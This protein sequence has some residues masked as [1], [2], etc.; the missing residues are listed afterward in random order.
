MEYPMLAM[1]FGRADASGNYTQALRNGA[2]SVIIHEVGHNFFPMIVNSDERQ[3]WWMD[4]GLNSFCQYVAEQEFEKG[5]P[6]RRGP[7]KNIVN[8]MKMPRE[9]MEPI[10]TKGDAVKDVG[11]NAYAKAATGL[12]MLREVIMG[13][14]LFDFSFREYARRWAFRHPT[15]ADLFRTME[16][17]S[18][19]DLDWFW[20]G[21]YFR[22][23]PVD[24]ALDSV[25]AMQSETPL[26]NKDVY[27]YELNVSNKGGMVMPVIIGWTYKDGTQEKEVV[28][29][30]VWMTNEQRF[31]K[32]FRKEKE[33]A[34]I[35]LDPDQVTTD[36]DPANGLWPSKSLPTK[37]QIFK[38]NMQ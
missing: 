16:D 2:I 30:G 38:Q 13:R 3:W 28:P 33:V 22:T 31:R 17:A 26:N 29:A 34:S 21:W 8:Y 35:Q 25:R 27:L 10:M 1:N 37:F 36:I 6:S 23:D 18:G 11:S 5:Y 19:Y 24:I 9:E 20:R 15:P 14:E 4:E 32:V 7:M 12:N